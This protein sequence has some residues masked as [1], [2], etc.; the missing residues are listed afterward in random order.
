MTSYTDSIYL[1]QGDDIFR[2]LERIESNQP[3]CT[4]QKLVLQQSKKRQS[5]VYGNLIAPPSIQFS[6]IIFKVYREGSQ[7]LQCA[8][9]Y[10]VNIMYKV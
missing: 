6:L 5:K 4:T 9:Y 3:C 1:C 2:T 10:T 7:C 8:L